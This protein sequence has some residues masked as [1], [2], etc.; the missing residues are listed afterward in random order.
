[1]IESYKYVALDYNEEHALPGASN[2]RYKITTDKG[3]DFIVERNLISRRIYC[4]CSFH[5]L[6]DMIC[7]H[8]FCLMNAL[9][10]KTI[11]RA[12]D[13]LMRWRDEP[14]PLDPSTRDMQPKVKQ[15]K[16]LQS[17]IDKLAEKHRMKKAK[18]KGGIVPLRKRK[19]EVDYYPSDGE[20]GETSSAAGADG[21]RTAK[22]YD[23]MVPAGMKIK[24]YSR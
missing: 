4:G 10:I 17:F 18:H 16:K 8:S 13:Y 23:L 24:A 1:M 19:V 11:S 5:I 20:E 9:Q 2:Q 12:F 3:I 14:N 7:A 15:Q 22:M 21:K 6:N